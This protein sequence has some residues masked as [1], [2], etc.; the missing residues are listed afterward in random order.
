M[1]GQR[2]D[3]T[4]AAPDPSTVR[5]RVAARVGGMP[6][7]VWGDTWKQGDADGMQLYDEVIRPLFEPFAQDLVARV[8]PAPGSTAFDLACGP[9]TVTRHLARAIGPEGRVIA[10]DISPA[11]LAIASAR[12][13]ERDA[14]PVEWIESPA[15]PL[16]LPDA[17]VQTFTCQQ[18]LQ[19]FPDQ[20][21]ALAEARRTLASEGVAAFAFWQ[22]L[23]ENPF[24]ELLHD[25]IRDIF[26]RELADRYASGPWSLDGPVAEQLA[27]DAGFGDVDLETVSL[28]SPLP[29]DPG[30]ALVR[31]LGASGIAQELGDLE[32][33][34]AQQ[35][36]ERCRAGIVDRFGPDARSAPF[37]TWLLVCRA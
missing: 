3:V 6:E 11:M 26:G 18:G 7:N 22:R 34:K 33:A 15:A 29:P 37:S 35:L 2:G 25:A 1:A 32:G 28:E 13:P 5:A 17:S 19:F 21:D 27:R 12:P 10:A 31:T 20:L 16:Q 30:A 8:A 4:S 14:A 23:S 24:F 36:L 9:G